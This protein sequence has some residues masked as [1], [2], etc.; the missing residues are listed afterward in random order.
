L[1][2]DG[3]IDFAD[4]AIVAS[5][6]LDESCSDLNAWCDGA[7]L[8][9]DT[10]VGFEDIV[11]LSE[12][13][14][15]EDIYPPIPD[16][17]RW[18]IEPDLAGSTSISMTAEPAFDAWGWDVEYWFERMPNGDPNSGW[19]DMPTWVDRGVTPGIRYGYRVKARDTSPNLNETGWSTVVYAG[20]EDL[21]PPAPAPT[22]LTAPYALSE[23][24]IAMVATTAFD[25]N[26]VEYYFENYSGNGNDSGWQTEPNYTDTVLDPN[27]AYC[28]RVKA[29]DRSANRNE[30]EWSV[31]ECATTL[32]PLDTTPPT[33]NPMQWDPT[34][35]PNGF[36]GTPHE[37]YGGGGTYDYSAA[38]RAVVA[39]DASG[40]VEY[41]FECSDSRYSSVWQAPNT[42]TVLV[43]SRGRGFSFRVKARDLWGN[44]TEWSQWYVMVPWPF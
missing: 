17:S 14:L 12:C 26:G 38:M 3:I 23:T 44:E 43:G 27:T 39:V 30:T 24:S 7:D 16:P 1:I 10:S 20:V 9:F 21:T 25:E 32:A 13:W 28:Y 8:T 31:V 22:W 35:D 33:P 36:D 18:E 37:I 34:V 15:V 5:S 42:Y 6:W 40:F 41:Y 29:R 4:F 19:V 2:F 11:F